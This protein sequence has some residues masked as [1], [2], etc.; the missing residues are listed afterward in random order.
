MKSE[1]VRREIERKGRG[2]RAS[3]EQRVVAAIALH[4][5]RML[6]FVKRDWYLIA[7]QTA[8]APHLAHPEG[9]VALRIVLGTVPR[10]SHSPEHFPDGFDLYLLLVW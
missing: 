3:S 7:E 6:T 8:P 4:C 1:E 10:V 2:E 5:K 9:F